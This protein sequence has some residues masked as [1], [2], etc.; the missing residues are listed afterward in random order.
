[1]QLDADGAAY[2]AWAKRQARAQ[3]ANGN[4]TFDRNWVIA[5]ISVHIRATEFMGNVLAKIWISVASKKKAVIVNQLARAYDWRRAFD[6]TLV[7]PTVAKPA[8]WYDQVTPAVLPA[9]A[10]AVAFEVERVDSITGPLVMDVGRNPPTG[11]LTPATLVEAFRKHVVA[12]HHAA[13]RHWF[14]LLRRYMVI[15]YQITQFGTFDNE[16]MVSRPDGSGRFYLLWG[17]WERTIP[18]DPTQPVEEQ[19]VGLII[20]S[21]SLSLQAAQATNGVVDFDRPTTDTAYVPPTRCGPGFVEYRRLQ[22]GLWPQ[23]AV[24]LVPPFR[25]RY[26]PEPPSFSSISFGSPY[27]VAHFDRQGVSTGGRDEVWTYT[28]QRRRLTSGGALV[29]EDV[30][31]P[32][33]A[34]PISTSSQD[35]SNHTLSM[36]VTAFSTDVVFFDGENFVK[37]G[38]HDQ[39]ASQ[40]VLKLSN[41]TSFTPGF[42]TVRGAFEGAAVRLGYAPRTGWFDY[43]V[44]EL[45]LA[46][47]EN[48][49][50]SQYLVPQSAFSSA[51]FSLS[52]ERDVLVSFTTNDFFWRLPRWG[53]GPSWGTFQYVSPPY[54]GIITGRIKETGFT[55][56]VPGSFVSGPFTG[57]AIARINTMT[58]FRVPR[59]ALWYRSDGAM[60]VF[61]YRLIGD[62]QA[63]SQKYRNV[64]LGLNGFIK[65]QPGWEDPAVILARIMLSVVIDVNNFATPALI[66]WLNDEPDMVIVEA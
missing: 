41:T 49:P 32:A 17:R 6:F 38:S 42:G 9:L 35:P 36:A 7:T 58:A 44:P 52:I 66:P 60:G 20:P 11:L 48:P 14:G 2:L 28:F 64:F 24:D 51:A 22:E 26:R 27:A 40:G 39:T 31:L 57:L 19:F 54:P 23:D 5:D 15:Q 16:M 10:P 61:I 34:T 25:F 4:E 18:N 30:P 50:G 47:T 13:I 65:T 62:I 1:M 53:G 43:F 45:G 46:H 33:L 63:D 59:G 37:V 29:L 21:A 56:V 12:G 55:C 3:V 8:A